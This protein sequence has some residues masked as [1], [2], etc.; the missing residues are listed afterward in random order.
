MSGCNQHFIR[1]GEYTPVQILQTQKTTNLL[2]NLNRKKNQKEIK[3]GKEKNGK[4]KKK[5]RPLFTGR[6]CASSLAHRRPVSSLTCRRAHPLSPARHAPLDPVV[7]VGG[8]DASSSRY[9]HASS[10]ASAPHAP[11][12]LAVVGSAGTSSSHCRRLR[13]LGLS[14][15]LLSTSAAKLDHCH[16]AC[17]LWQPPSSPPLSSPAL[18][19]ALLM[20]SLLSMVSRVTR[21][22]LS[23]TPP[24]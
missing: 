17:R 1:G 10:L 5:I 19:V 9:R 12:D 16:H 2:K 23:L 18:A 21:P 4:K 22:T 7:I 24:A 11:P 8:G 6:R 3:G 20:S 14:L 15:L 13:P